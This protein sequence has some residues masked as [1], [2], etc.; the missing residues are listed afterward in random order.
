MQQRMNPVKEIDENTQLGGACVIAAD[1]RYGLGLLLNAEEC[2][3]PEGGIS[4][5]NEAT[6]PPV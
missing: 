4:W 6:I 1:D 3:S 2:D 5:W